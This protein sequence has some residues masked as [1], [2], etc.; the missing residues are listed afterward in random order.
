MLSHY[1]LVEKI[2]EGGM[3][4]VWKALDTELNRHVAIK[5]LPPELTAD[6]ERRLRFK[7]E[8]Q[9]AAALSHPNIAVIHEVGEHE[10]TPF[11]VME[12]LEGK[13]LRKQLHDRPL[14]LKEWL[15]LAVPV[16]EGL[17][18]AHKHGIV[19]RDLKPDNVMITDEGQVKLLDFGLAKL[20]QPEALPAG[21]DKELESRLQ[22]I[23]RELTR[24]GKVF[25]TVAYMSP[26]QAR[27]EAADHRSDLFSLG[28]MLYEMAT[29]RLP[30]KG[31]SD[32]E[33]LSAT[34]AAE[35]QPLSQVVEELPAE[36]ER[37]VRKALEKETE[38]RYQDAAD[39]AADLKN[40]QRDLES[41]RASI[42]S[43]VT[44]GVAG[45]Q[46]PRWAMAGLLGAAVILVAGVAY[47]S[48]RWQ[49]APTV[50]TSGLQDRAIAVIG[51]ENLSD[52]TDSDHLGR[53]LM[54][55][56]TTDLAESGGLPVVSMPKVLAALRQVSP[57][58]GAEFDASVASEAAQSAGAQVMLVGQVGSAG[59]RLILTAEL[60]DVESGEVLGSHH[61][62]AGSASELFSL[63]G[64]IAAE[65]RGHLPIAADSTS[66]EP[67]DL[68]QALT[69]SPEAYRHYAAGE[70]ALHQIRWPD[71]IERFEHA[72][73]EDPTFALAYYRL[74]VAEWWG[75]SREESTV[76]LQN[77]LPYVD[78]LPKR[79]QIVYQGFHDYFEGRYDASYNA[80]SRLVQSSS[81]ISEAY[82]ILGEIA[83]HANRYL[84]LGKAR[85]HFGKVLEIDPTF[86]LVLNHL[87]GD[88]I[89]GEDLD[90]ANRLIE[91]YREEDPA[92][93]AVVDAE[94]YVLTAQ[95]RF[96]EAAARGEELMARGHTQ[97]WEAL[98]FSY[99]KAGNWERAYMIADD[100]TRR[101]LGYQR[102]AAFNARG[103][104]H[105]GRGRLREGLN[106]LQEAAAQAVSSGAADWYGSMFHENCAQ[107]LE[108]VGD[109]GGAVAEIRQAIRID[110]FDHS[111][112]YFLG[113]ILL[114]AGRKLEAE[115]TLVRLRDVARESVTPV[116]QFWVH[117]L[118]AESHLA[119]G[120]VPEAKS[121][122]AQA[123]SLA[124]EHRERTMEWLTRA[125]VRAASGN[126]PGATAAYREMLEPQ[127]LGYW[128]VGKTRALYALARLEE[129][130]GDLASAR[131]HYREYLSRWG[132]AD[133]EV[134]EVVEAR[135]RVVALEAK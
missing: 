44:I 112:Y 98:S 100:A 69:S 58:E 32:V 124:P 106:D 86:K 133:M 128:V 10:G 23:S 88:Y 17:A 7:R 73:R 82:Y 43:G 37:V 51:F 53:M 8:A 134:P 93:P 75:G 105:V 95:G 5:I 135:S 126:R 27:G 2:G 74:A 50:A 55:L 67:F 33:A 83:T 15:S 89:Q 71:A 9:A 45:R 1:R 20:L 78:R 129:E 94:V 92:D 48:T 4:I 29:G 81:D 59:D 57:T 113:R 108:A 19:H 72:I 85:E 84:D 91:R 64:A 107:V 99:L 30:F 79:W 110:R 76:A 46:Q 114:G 111:A 31:K 102:F 68:A 14:P 40:L 130:T 49:P 121:V 62:E 38:R 3:G 42:P 109:L 123:S 120:N 65:V 116:G 24:A 80:L 119:E 12:F 125:R 11:I 118:Q 104:A 13:S 56:I 21:T 97:L 70:F 26:E 25:G 47:L 28:V 132:E 60:I 6:A 87:I 16:A 101:G 39:L 61:K 103:F 127:H 90:A 54:G 52:P 41:G 63:A 122:L 36:A 131:E 66:P 96:D 18:H 115:E 22:T 35:P 77:G 34:I 117:L